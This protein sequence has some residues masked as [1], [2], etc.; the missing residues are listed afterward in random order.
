MVQFTEEEYQAEVNETFVS[1]G[2]PRPSPGFITVSC[3]GG[4]NTTYSICVSE[5]FPFDI[6]SATGE[7]SV[8]EDLDYDTGTTSYSFNVTCFEAFSSDVNDTATILVTLLPV[9]EFAPTAGASTVLV[10]VL[11]DTPIGTVIA[12]NADT[13]PEGVQDTYDITDD[14]AGPDGILTFT[15]DDIDTEFFTLDITT[16]SITLLRDLDLDNLTDTIPTSFIVSVTGCDILPPVVTCPN[17]AVRIFVSQVN[18]FQPQFSQDVYNASIAETASE[19]TEVVDVSCTDGDVGVGAV[20]NIEF[21][22][23]SQQ[24]TDAFMIDSSTGSITLIVVSYEAIPT[25]EFMVRCVDTGGLESFAN[26]SIDILP[27]TGKWSL[28]FWSY[29]GERGAY[30]SLYPNLWKL[31][32]FLPKHRFS[33]FYQYK[34]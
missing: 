8:T 6:D 34:E 10:L 11:E 18:E 26:V 16:G 19:G 9:N 31:G 7:L 20:G 1:G 21:L 15:S 23:P 27:A 22:N 3:T 30:Q 17:V 28:S 32:P 13:A 4:I 33:M 14:D 5:V 2:Y 12:S 24:L 29:P 25:Y